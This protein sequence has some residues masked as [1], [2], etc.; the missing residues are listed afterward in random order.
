MLAIGPMT[1]AMSCAVPVR[2][3]CRLVSQHVN[4]TKTCCS[5]STSNRYHFVCQSITQYY[6]PRNTRRIHTFTGSSKTT[7][8]NFDVSPCPT[9]ALNLLCALHTNTVMQILSSFANA[10]AVGCVCVGRRK[11]ELVAST[12]TTFEFRIYIYILSHS[13]ATH[14]ASRYI[15]NNER[16]AHTSTDF[17]DFRSAFGGQHRSAVGKHAIS[18]PSRVAPLTSFNR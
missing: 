8:E 15:N 3:R 16:C 1:Y 7:Y 11:H 17:R 10:A 5:R 12:C 4:I 13:S 9:N 6:A 14:Y 18:H 2:T